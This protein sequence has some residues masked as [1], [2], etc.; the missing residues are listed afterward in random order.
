MRKQYKHFMELATLNNDGTTESAIGNYS[1]TPASFQIVA[2]PGEE[3]VIERMILSIVDG[4][5]SNAE[6]YGGLGAPLTNG[7]VISIKDLSGTIE[8]LTP[9]PILTNGDWAACCHDLSNHTSVGGG[10][11]DVITVRWTFTRSG[12]PLVLRAAEGEYIE[13]LLNDDFTGLIKHRFFFQ[14]YFE[15]ET[16]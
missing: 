2:P 15:T 13:V 14:G 11:R 4:S 7:I 9:Y 1:V 16:Y 5:I 12:Q 3:I 10:S 8:T 6:N